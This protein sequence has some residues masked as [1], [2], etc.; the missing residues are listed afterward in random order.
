[1]SASNNKM[2]AIIDNDF[3]I[4]RHLER[5]LAASG[6]ATESFAS[7][8]EFLADIETCRPSCL[9]LDAGLKDSS[10]REFFR[11]PTIR[12]LRCPVVFTSAS[13]SQDPQRQDLEMIRATCVRKPFRAVDILPVIARAVRAS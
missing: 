10:G 12:A 7:A 8:E 1:M 2:L 9:V 6:Y 4:R 5:L 3:L 11:H 13:A